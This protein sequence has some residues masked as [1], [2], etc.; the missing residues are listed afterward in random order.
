MSAT[1]TLLQI[2]G[3]VALMLWGL[4]MIHSGVL[5]AFGGDLRHVLMQ[6]L[7]SRWKAALA[8]LGITALLQSST[9]TGLMTQSFIASGLMTLATAIAVMLGANV[10]TTLIVQLLTFDVAA[11]A[12]VLVLVGLIAFKRGRATR[13]RDI[14]RVIIGLGLLLLALHLVLQA[15]RPVENAQALRD[16]FTMLASDPLMNIVIAALLTW[17]AHSSVAIVLFVMTLASGGIIPVPA[18]LALVLG[19]NLGS[20]IPQY[21]AVRANVDAGRLIL[22]SFIVRG[23]GCVVAIPFLPRIADLIAS[24]DPD[25]ARQ[26]ADFHTLFNLALALLFLALLDPLARLCV[27][28]LP[29]AQPAADPARPRYIDATML[30]NPAIALSN[31]ER[32]VL[33]MIDVVEAMLQ[34]FLAAIEKD[35]RKRLSAIAAKD[36]IVDKLHRA[37]KMYLTRVGRENT[38]NEAEAKRCSDILAFAI[39]LEH[40]GDILDKN[41]RDLAAKK[42]RNR[43]NFSSEG[44][45]EIKDMHQGTLDNL[46]LATSVFMSGDATS[47]RRLLNAKVRMRNLEAT[48]TG[49]HLRRL[50]EGRPESLET[51]ALHIDIARDLKR[52]TAHEVAVAYPILEAEGAL[53]PSRLRDSEPAVP[54]IAGGAPSPAR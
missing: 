12:P 7:N 16:L 30:R 35:D 52:I 48:L 14:G 37:I 10:G 6:G 33:R 50:R 11:I 22:A 39:N 19:A 31:A 21:F 34:D 18:A 27:R 54:A 8:G 49:N 28:L 9:A 3:F 38:L 43:L 47:A 41:L 13:V 44:L 2:A 32:E 29:S 23:V 45:A 42:I 20:V 51:S 17:A 40:I 46:K 15:L 26:V 36:D 5:R 25:I 53:R 24:V 1:A 4:H